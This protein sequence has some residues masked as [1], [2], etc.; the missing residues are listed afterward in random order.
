MKNNHSRERGQVLVLVALVLVLLMGFAGLALDGGNIYTDRRSAQAAADTAALSGALAVVQGYAPYQVGEI[1][2]YRAGE[3]GYTDSATVTVIVNWPPAAPHPY[4]GDWRYVQVLITHQLD[5]IFAHFFSD[6]PF[7]HP[8]EAVAHARVNEDLLP[9][10][11]RFRV[12]DGG[13][14]VVQGACTAVREGLR[15]VSAHRSE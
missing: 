4:A 6:G 12:C 2:R 3:N 11:V 8:V 13:E 9:G 15:I 14:E 1:A 7:I 10:H 5:T